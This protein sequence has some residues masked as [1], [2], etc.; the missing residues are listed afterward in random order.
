[1][2]GEGVDEVLQLE[3]GMREVRRGPKGVNKCGTGKLTKGGEEWW[4]EDVM[5]AAFRSTSTDMRPRREGKG[6][7]GYSGVL[8]REEKRGKKRGARR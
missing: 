7:M 3:E 2:A 6:V 5:M 4:R 1:V 8:T